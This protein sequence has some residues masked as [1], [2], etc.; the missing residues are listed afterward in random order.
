MQLNYMDVDSFVLCSDTQE[1]S[2]IDFLQQNKNE[3]DS[4]QS[5]ENHELFDSS[6]EN[7]IEKL[8]I[9]TSPVLVIDTFSALRTKTYSFSYN[10]ITK[11]RKARNVRGYKYSSVIFEYLFKF[12]KLFTSFKPSENKTN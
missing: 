6:N 1:Q 12:Y 7:V 5:N 10:S 11:G 3:F 9:K 4:K 2:L 8:K